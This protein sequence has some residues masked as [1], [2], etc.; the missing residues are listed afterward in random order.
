MLELARH[1]NIFFD[2]Q[3]LFLQ[4]TSSRH[5]IRKSA[6]WK[7]SSS[8]RHELL[9][10]DG[11]ARCFSWVRWSSLS[12][13]RHS[14]EYGQGW[15]F[16]FM[17]FYESCNK[18]FTEWGH[19]GS[20]SPSGLQLKTLA[21]PSTI[22]PKRDDF[23]SVRPFASDIF[24]AHDLQI[25]DREEKEHYHLIWNS[26][27]SMDINRQSVQMWLL[28]FESVPFVNKYLRECIAIYWNPA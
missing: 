4:S 1:M 5:G 21:T 13:S 7:G 26:C 12:L 11:S 14:S 23:S 2:D 17:C 19:G 16:S 27:Q 9:D 6:R 28:N 15:E 3:S 20:V 24:H 8:L 18:Q 10:G 22:L 25:S